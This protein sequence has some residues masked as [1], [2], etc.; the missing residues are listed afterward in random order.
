MGLSHWK[1]TVIKVDLK[2]ADVYDGYGISKLV[3]VNQLDD[4]LLNNYIEWLGV[5]LL[6][7]SLF[8]GSFVNYNYTHGPIMLKIDEVRFQKL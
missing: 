3:Y 6:C 8:L 5:S 7:F 4:S 2:V 1:S